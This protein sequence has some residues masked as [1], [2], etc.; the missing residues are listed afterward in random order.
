M[1]LKSQLLPHKPDDL[2]LIPTTK[3]LKAI[4]ADPYGKLMGGER[5]TQKL[6]GQPAW[7]LSQQGGE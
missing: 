7:S 1:V 2:S 4:P 6:M 3:N 5:L